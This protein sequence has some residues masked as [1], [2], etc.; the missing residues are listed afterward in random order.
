M[1]NGEIRDEQLARLVAEE[2]DY[3]LSSASD[4]RLAELTVTGVT[5]KAGGGHFIVYVAPQEGACGFSSITEMKSALKRASSFLRY[6]LGGALNLK[7]TPDLTVIPDPF[8]SY[9]WEK[10]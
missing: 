4:P 3:V 9:P 8:Y 10:E 7:R 6:E 1:K 5:P 2:L